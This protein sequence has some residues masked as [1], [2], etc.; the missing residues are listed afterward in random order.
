MAA[1]MA[2]KAAKV[3][4]KTGLWKTALWKSG[5]PEMAVKY[6]CDRVSALL[7]DERSEREAFQTALAGY[8]DDELRIFVPDVYQE[9]IYRIDY[10]LLREKGIRLISF[11]IDDTIDDSFINKLEANVPG[12][13]VTM[14]ARARELVRGLKGM[15]FTVVLLTNAQREL[16]E[17]ACKD[18]GADSCIARAK[19]PDTGGFEAIS[20]RYGVD[21]S[22]MAHVGNSIRADIAGGNRYGV[23]TCLVRRAGTSM[24]IV[25]LGLKILGMPTKGHLIRERLLE[26]GLWRKHSAYNA[27]DQYYQLGEEPAYR[28]Q[29]PP[30]EE[31]SSVTVFY[32]GKAPYTAA[33]NLCRHI[34]SL[35]VEAGLKAAE[36]YRQGDPGKSIII[37]HHDLAKRQLAETGVLYNSYGMMLGCTRDQCVLRVSRSAL[38]KGKKGRR[39]F[40]EYYNARMPLYRELADQYGVPMEFGARDKTRKSQYDLIWLEFAARWLNGF[41]GRTGRPEAESGSDPA[42]QAAED[43]IQKISADQDQAYTLDELLL[44][45]YQAKESACMKTLRTHLGGDIVFTGL[46]ADAKDERDLEEAELL[47]GELAGCVF[48]V[49]GYDI[50]GAVCLFRDDDEAD[51]TQQIPAGP[52]AAARYREDPY[53]M[54]GPGG[55]F[56]EVQVISARYSGSGSEG[57]QQVCI[58]ASSIRWEERI[59]FVGTL[60]PSAS[61]PA[62]QEA[63]FVLKQYTGDSFGVAHWYQLSSGGS[64]TEYEEHPY[65]PESFEASWR[66]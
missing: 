47:E 55:G 28:R 39:K 21:R 29:A 3:L 58:A 37:G 34:R 16:A 50:R 18:L 27:G 6:V 31:R 64:V 62:G 8:S 42:R 20:A 38:G 14:P 9:D 59:D 43:L 13:S 40:E 23:T 33:F 54:T 24:K 52:E 44:N 53:G 63:L 66:D 32:D 36:D 26:R 22:Q 51:Y 45:A 4:W 15:G 2:L 1:K 19:K 17:G 7:A 11:D 41:L 60:K 35:G 30:A 48:T 65:D 25:K 56:R 61:A 12:L 46:W 5:L 49:G 57:W 10:S